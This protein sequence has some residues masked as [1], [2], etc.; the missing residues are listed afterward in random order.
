MYQIKEP[1][2]WVQKKVRLMTIDEWEA[3]GKFVHLYKLQLFPKVTPT[4]VFLI[5]IVTNIQSACS[6]G[7]I[8][9]FHNP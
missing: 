3:A 1:Q 8:G 5:C 6:P 7:S 4:S 2:F 9:C